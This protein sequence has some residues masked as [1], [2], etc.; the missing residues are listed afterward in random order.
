MFIIA[1]DESIELNEL[2]NLL[3]NTAK[4]KSEAIELLVLAACQTAKG[5]KRATLGLAGVAINAGVRSTLATLWKVIADESPGELLNQFYQELSE[6]PEL[7]KAEALRRAQ[8]EFL[9]DDSR[10]RP[11][12]WATYI[13]LGNWL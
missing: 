11:Y 9:K 13:L 8:L 5:D 6:H 10:N 12:Y 7:T 4:T 1:W 3:K 2:S